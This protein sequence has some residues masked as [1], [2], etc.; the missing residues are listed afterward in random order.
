MLATKESINCT[1]YLFGDAAKK[2][3][4]STVTNVQKQSLESGSEL[5]LPLQEL[6]HN[7]FKSFI[8]MTD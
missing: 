2:S 8:L 6:W 4:K 5:C 1:P 3:S 7:T